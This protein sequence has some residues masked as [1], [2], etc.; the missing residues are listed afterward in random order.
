MQKQIY[1]ALDKPSSL[2]GIQGSY[3]RWAAIG[4]GGAALLGLFVSQA[5]VGLVGFGVFAVAGGAVYLY[6]IRYQSK[7]SER[8]RDK[9][10]SARE[11][12]DFVVMPDHPLS[13]EPYVIYTTKER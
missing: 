1:R 7:Y 6:I 4:M 9:K 13:D 12:P 3:Q 8:E 2:L 11:M 5:T 10:L